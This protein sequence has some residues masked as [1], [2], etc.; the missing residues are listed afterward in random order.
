MDPGRHED[1]NDWQYGLF[2][3]F[4]DCRLCLITFLVPCYTIGEWE[5]GGGW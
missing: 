2:G 5:G 1:G 3:C 4:G